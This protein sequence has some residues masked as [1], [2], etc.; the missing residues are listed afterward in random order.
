MREYIELGSAP[1]DEECV[2]VGTENYAALGRKECL[3]FI[4]LLRKIFGDE[5][6]SARLCFKSFPHDFGNYYEVVCYYDEND[7]SAIEYAF[8]IEGNLPLTWND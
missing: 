4:N 2:Q 3:R 5:P 7:K 8:N 6:G 1:V